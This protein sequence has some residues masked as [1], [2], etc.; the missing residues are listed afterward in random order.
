MHGKIKQKFQ[1][2]R[3]RFT[4]LNEYYYYTENTSIYIKSGENDYKLYTG[5]KPNADDGNEYYYQK[6]VYE[7]DGGMQEFTRMDKASLNLVTA[8][9]EN[10]GWAI[11]QGTFR[12]ETLGEKDKGT[13]GNATGTT[14]YVFKRKYRI[15]ASSG[16]GCFSGRNC[17]K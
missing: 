1:R 10:A 5:E 6:I 13:N 8:I 14:G 16:K 3:L 2:Q 4:L 15:L 17:W 9:D 11:P 7:L 12:Q